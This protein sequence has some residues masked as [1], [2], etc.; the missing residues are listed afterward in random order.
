M[1][2][3]SHIVIA[4]A[5]EGISINGKEYLLDDDGNAMEFADKQAAKDFLRENGCDLTDEEMADS[6][7][8]VEEQH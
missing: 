5:I 7:D 1:S 6:F 2:Q 3:S 8:F 4:R